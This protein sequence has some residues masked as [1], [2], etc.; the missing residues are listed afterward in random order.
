MEGSFLHRK[1]N[2][3]IRQISMPARR[4]GQRT[5]SKIYLLRRAVFV[6]A[7][8][9]TSSFIGRIVLSFF[10][11]EYVSLELSGNMHYTD[12]QIYD[13]LGKQLQNIVT[14]SEG[15][16]SIYLKKNLSYIKDAHVT[17]HVMKR[18]L[19][20]EITEREPFV[21]L[22]VDPTANAAMNRD[23]SFF[24]VD[25][26]GHVL[27]HVDKGEGH[28]RISDQFGK[29][30]VLKAVND[31]LPKVGTPVG[32]PEVALGLEILKT[33]LFREQNLATQIESINA[34]DSEKIKLQLD[35]FPVSVWLSAD[36]IESGLRHIAL[37]LQQYKIQVLQRIRENSV[38]TQPYLDAR[39]Q[40]TIYL[41]GLA[42]S[43]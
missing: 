11:A 38:K 28:P 18:M 25:N 39:F 19:T 17:K 29:M 8:V 24:L 31:E 23:S 3:Y 13:A 20:I 42:E 7:I 34:S 21:L 35:A 6:V 32:M 36:A 5:N 14:D 4:L 12:V 41:G 26:E 9:L 22:R 43:K 15:Q 33:A 30:V 40:D 16:T 1:R 2:G 27:K 10:G 37:F